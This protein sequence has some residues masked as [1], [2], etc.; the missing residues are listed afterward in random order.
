MG[1]FSLSPAK[2][3]LAKAALATA[4]SLLI[5]TVV[6]ASY[7]LTTAFNPGVDG[8]LHFDLFDLLGRD[9]DGVGVFVGLGL[10][11]SDRL[12]N[13]FLVRNL[14]VAGEFNFFS[15]G[16]RNHFAH[17][18]RTILLVGD[19]IG[20]GVRNIFSRGHRDHFTHRVGL[21]LSVGDHFGD[22]VRNV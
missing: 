21:L 11:P 15:L 7:G 6:V 14:P 20:D 13:G 18:V 19:H 3:A 5:G 12:L 8:D 4:A 10:H 2:A 9:L 22:V 17:G 1:G 16:H